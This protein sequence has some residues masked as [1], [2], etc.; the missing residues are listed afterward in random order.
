ML[1]GKVI[2]ECLPRH[3]SREFIRFLARI[4]RETPPDL[5]L[6][7][8]V[9]NARTH[10]SPPVKRWLNRHP[11]FH[12]HVIPTSSSWLNI[13]ERWFRDI[14]Q[15]RIRRGTF[16][17]VKDSSPPSTTTSS[18]TITPRPVSCGPRMPP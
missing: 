18:T 12:L 14:T 6:H 1:D 13:V 3:R 15:R 11:R 2:G 7:L 10:K 8:I 9:D 5:A 4:D 17:S 16:R